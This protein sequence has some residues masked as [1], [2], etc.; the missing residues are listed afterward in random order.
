VTAAAAI[1]LEN[2]RLQVELR[3]RVKELQE[4]RTRML[5]AGQEE[6]QRLERNLHD[7]AQQR[8]VSLSLQLGLLEVALHGD[9]DTSARLSQARQ[10]IAASLEELRDVARGIYP[11]VLSGHGLDVALDSLAVSAPVP[12]RL[13]ASVSGR[14]PAAVEATAYYVVSEGLANIGKHA[15]ATCAR[16]DVSTANGLLVVEVVDDGVGGADTE[17]GSG[18][19]GLADRVEALGGHLRIWTPIGGGTRIRAEIPCR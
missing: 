10:E 8:L 6:R 17:A 18:L 13:N 14:L 1:A 19:R 9:P 15:R 11:A 4:S 2:D 16:V 3:A 5:E 12:L 7:G